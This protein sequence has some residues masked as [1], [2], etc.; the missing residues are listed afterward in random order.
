MVDPL[1]MPPI[2]LRRAVGGDESGFDNPG[3]GLVYDHIPQAA[4]ERVF[5]F[6]CGCGRLARQLMQQRAARP[7]RYLGI[8]LHKAAVDWA[9]ANLSPLDRNFRF[10]HFD[11]HNRQFNPTAM[12]SQQAFPTGE[13]FTLA[14]ANSVFTH[15]LEADVAFYLREIARIL[16]RDGYFVSSWFFFDKRSFP[17]M[18]EFQNALY[19]NLDDPT[20]AVI[21]DL[22]FARALFRGAG[23]TIIQVLPPHLR[24]FQWL[25]TAVLADGRAEAE[26][27]PDVAPYGLARPPL[28]MDLHRAEMQPPVP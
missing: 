14:V 7:R 24:G 8:D 22:D 10:E 3:G 13:K 21:Y 11:V 20:N 5:D 4:Y 27:P 15:V 9:S 1:P 28:S 12:Q 6:G 2:E 19:I 16:A 23:L 18:Q 26:F 17:M 25:L